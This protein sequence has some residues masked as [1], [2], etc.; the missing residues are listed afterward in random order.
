MH[1]AGCPELP[2]GPGPRAWPAGPLAGN[3]RLMGKDVY[4]DEAEDLGHV[5]D[6]M[7]D[8]ASGRVRYAVLALSG[9]PGAQDRLLP[10]PWSAL[11]LDSELRRFV[12]D[13]DRARL[14]QAP[15]FAPG[16][17]PDLDDPRWAGEIDAWYR[18]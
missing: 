14:E 10:V 4:N 8:L 9:R 15:G 17:W 13:I 1:R 16:R 3:T 5:R 18:G 11:R 2:T 12:L 6:L 7:L